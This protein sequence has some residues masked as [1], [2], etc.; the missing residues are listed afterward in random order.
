MGEVRGN[1]GD[2]F[3]DFQLENVKVEAKD[4]RWKPPTIKGLSIM[5]FTINGREVTAPAPATSNP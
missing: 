5:G 4:G 2:T 3:E 1:P